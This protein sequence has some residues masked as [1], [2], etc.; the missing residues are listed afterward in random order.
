MLQRIWVDDLNQYTILTINQ[1]GWDTVAPKFYGATALPDY[2]PF[3]SSEDQLRLLGNVSGQRVL[4]LGCGSGHSLLYLAQ[5]GA[6]ELWGLDLAAAQIAA[7]TDLLHAREITAQLFTSPMEHNPGI[8]TNYF[9][10]VISIYALGWT[11]DLPQTLAHVAAYLKRNGRFVFSW[12]HPL[13]PCLSYADGRFVLARS[14]Q[15]EGPRLAE[16]WLGVP[17]VRQARKLSTFLNAL[18]DQGLVVER[19]LE[20]EPTVDALPVQDDPTAYYSTARAALVPATFIVCA[21]KP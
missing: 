6:A 9:D 19:V 15:T 20:P 2:G 17:I 5:Q 4:E 16:S 14:Y 13:H 3:A 7:A 21:R 11:A 10:L 18:L 12:E 8:P 1:A